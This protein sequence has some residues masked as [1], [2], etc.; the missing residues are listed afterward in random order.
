VHTHI[1]AWKR[2]CISLFSYRS[3]LRIQEILALEAEV[4]DLVA[5]RRRRQRKQEKV[6]AEAKA[7]LESV[8]RTGRAV[9]DRFAAMEKELWASGVQVYTCTP[10]G[11]IFFTSLSPNALNSLFFCLFY[12]FPF[13]RSSSS[14]PS[15]ARSQRCVLRRRLP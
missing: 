3:L 7:K 12:L 6:L 11:L 2:G 8:K 10:C 13:F 5:E 1:D 15:L 4:R 9:E 14:R